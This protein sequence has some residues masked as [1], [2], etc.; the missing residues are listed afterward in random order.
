VSARDQERRRRREIEIL[1]LQMGIEYPWAAQ[2]R[3]QREV[4]I[5]RLS[6]GPLS[7]GR[8]SSAGPRR[9]AEPIAE[10]ILEE[11]RNLKARQ[12][13]RLDRAGLEIHAGELRCRCC[14]DVLV[15]LG[16]HRAP[17]P[18][19]RAIGTSPSSL[20]LHHASACSS[21]ARAG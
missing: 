6:D 5:A 13:R 9:R 14:G 3:R 4:D 16:A 1:C 7:A 15:V 12:V 21:K 18:G 11:A 20:A 2:E 17:T 10:E 8:S 19:G